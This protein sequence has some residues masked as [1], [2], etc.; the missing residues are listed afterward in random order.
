MTAGGRGSRLGRTSPAA[1]GAAGAAAGLASVALLHPLDTVKVRMQ[2]QGH[3]EPG[4]AARRSL[5][6]YTSATHALLTIVATEG[7]AALYVGLTPAV[8]GGALAWGTYFASY[9]ACKGLV[10]SRGGAAAAGSSARLS[11]AAH[12]G[13]A[14]A[15][16]AVVCGVTNPVWVVKTRLQL[17]FTRDQGQAP[18]CQ[19]G[20]Y[21]GLVHGL[22][23]LAAEEGLRGYFYGIVPNLALVSHG[24]LQFMAYEEMKG[25]LGGADRPLQPAEAGAAGMASKLFAQMATYPSQVLRSRMQQ[26]RPPG[27]PPAT[28]FGT[29]LSLWRAEGLRGF[30]RGLPASVYRVLPASGVTFVVYESVLAAISV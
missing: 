14:A 6:Y 25:A 10:R 29:A 8:V 21:R 4:V 28:V 1:Q 18:A 3:R 27:A 26:R 12:L 23:T 30:Y 9:E 2:V 15:A 13:C 7:L 19:H 11:P 17:Q 5:P 22:R 20:A 16:G 24:A